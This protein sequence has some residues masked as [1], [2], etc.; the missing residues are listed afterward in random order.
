MSATANFQIEDLARGL[1][2]SVTDGKLV[3]RITGTNYK[4]HLVPSGSI[5]RLA[6]NVGKRVKGRIHANALRLFKAEGGGGGQFIEPIWGQ[7]RIVAGLVQHVDAANRRILVEIAVPMW[8]T[9]EPDQKPESFAPGDMVNC[10][11][12]SGATFSPA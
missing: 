4:I 2:E 12:Q 6:P 11:V 10:Y 8:L 7:P 3:L 9:V 1:L 5:S